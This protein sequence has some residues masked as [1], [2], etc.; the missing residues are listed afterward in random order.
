MKQYMLI[1]A[2]CLVSLHVA[3]YDCS[4]LEVTIENHSSYQC[5]LT[6]VR[7]FNGYFVEHAPLSLLPQTTYA[8]FHLTEYGNGISFNLDYRC[9][10][11]VVIIELGQGH[12]GFLGGY[13]YGARYT[14]NDLKIDY[15]LQEGSYWSGTPGQVKV[16][17]D[18]K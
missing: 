7:M 14:G 9:D 17:F 4:N 10:G 2:M 6:H 15:E 1:I 18:D 8:P 12:C 5:Q 3:A 13:V 11:K 16:I